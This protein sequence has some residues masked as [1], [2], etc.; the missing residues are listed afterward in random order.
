MITKFFIWLMGQTAQLVLSL[1][2]TGPDP[3]SS[4]SSATS[5]IGQVFSWAA[6]LGNWVPWSA[7]G[8]ALVVVG[9][10][11]VTAGV[12]KLVRIVASFLTLGGGS[13]A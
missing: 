12:I 13:A 8:P 3:S 5:G 4:I 2:P 7:V 11:L 6:A 10:A 1:F 9:G